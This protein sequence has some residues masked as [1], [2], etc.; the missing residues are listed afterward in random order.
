LEAAFRALFSLIVQDLVPPEVVK[1]I[2]ELVL[3][4]LTQLPPL[5]VG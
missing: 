3:R 2:F 5:I 4:A 1:Y